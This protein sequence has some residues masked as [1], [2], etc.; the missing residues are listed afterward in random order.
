MPALGYYGYYDLKYI[1]KRA[2]GIEAV[3]LGSGLG[4]VLLVWVWYC[5]SSFFIAVFAGSGPKTK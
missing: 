5:A 3:L 4:L 1:M 2:Q